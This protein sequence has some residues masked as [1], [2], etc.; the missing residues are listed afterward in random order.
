MKNIQK[1]LGIVLAV[2]MALALMAM[3]CS[4]EGSSGSAADRKVDV[5]IVG[6]GIAGSVA[7]AKAADAGVQALLI[8]KLA[9]YGGTSVTAGGGYAGAGVRDGEFTAND[10]WNKWEEEATRFDQ[11]DTGY[12]IEADIRVLAPRIWPTVE[13][14]NSITCDA[15]ME[16]VLGLKPEQVFKLFGQPRYL[17]GKR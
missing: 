3:G 15:I 1:P 4:D 6:S 12:P 10:F 16:A 5:L 7:A 11:D 17:L 8:E 2:L 9:I 13:Y 14:I